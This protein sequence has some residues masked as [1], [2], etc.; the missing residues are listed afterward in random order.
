MEVRAARCS[1]TTGFASVPTVP[2][3][4]SITG[5]HWNGSV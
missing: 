2:F 1:S 5:G 4:A 3:V